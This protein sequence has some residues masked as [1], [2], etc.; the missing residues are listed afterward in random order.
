[1]NRWSAFR[2]N[3]DFRRELLRVWWVFTIPL[4]VELCHSL[5]V[6]EVKYYWLN[7][8]A[9]YE[10]IEYF[11]FLCLWSHPH[12][13]PHICCPPFFPIAFGLLLRNFFSLPFYV[14]FFFCFYSSVW[15][16]FTY[17]ACELVTY[18]HTFRPFVYLLM[19]CNRFNWMMS[20]VY[21]CDARGPSV[22][23]H[24]VGCPYRGLTIDTWFWIIML[25]YDPDLC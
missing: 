1:M 5:A 9:Y 24:P 22:C 3:C 8:C 12:F 14:F 10:A 15:S 17:F 25:I 19:D 13:S 4:F 18:F 11:C 20:S 2:C 21:L 6:S 16:G 23:H 7:L